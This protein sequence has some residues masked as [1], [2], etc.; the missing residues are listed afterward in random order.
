MVALLVGTVLGVGRGGG[1]G[2]FKVHYNLQLLAQAFNPS[3]WEI[4]ATEF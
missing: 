3:M 2:S 1:R 4:E